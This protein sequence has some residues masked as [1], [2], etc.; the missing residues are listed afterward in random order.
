MVVE[1]N[2]LKSFY[3]KGSTA[4]FL[5]TETVEC[6]LSEISNHSFSCH[7]EEHNLFEYD[8]QIF[9]YLYYIG[10]DVYQV[11]SYLDSKNTVDIE[12][13]KLIIAENKELNTF[14]ISVNTFGVKCISCPPKTQQY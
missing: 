11:N 10:G 8:V 4:F 14:T 3:V 9:L 1:Q 5:R 2:E 12:S 6:N 7:H 13:K